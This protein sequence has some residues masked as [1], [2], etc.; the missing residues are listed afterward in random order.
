MLVALAMV[1][2]PLIYLKL[3]FGAAWGVYYHAVYHWDPI[4]NWGGLR[5]PW[6]VLL[7]TTIYLTPLLAGVVVVFFLFKPLFARRR[8]RAQPLA[9]NPANEPVLFAF[10]EAICRVVG[11]PSPR[12]IDL[13]CHLNASAGFRRGLLSL[14]GNDL[15]LTLGL[16]LVANV[17]TK[18]LAGIIA[19]EFGHFTQGAGIR[20]SYIIRSVS[21]WFARVVYERDAWD[22]ALEEW[23]NEI[24]DGR[25]AIVVGLVQLGVWFSRLILRVLMYCGYLVGGYMLRQME[26]NADAYE[27]KV[28]GSEGF[29]RTTR[30]LALL[31][32][33][34]H[35][36]YRQIRVTWN[37]SGSLPDNLPELLRSSHVE[38]PSH[39]RQRIDD[40]LGM[41][42]T[43]A[44]DTHPSP[45]D[46]IREAR[47]AADPGIFEDDRPATSLFG[48]F[49]HPARQVTFLHYTEELG[50]PV[51]PEM[52]V[53][54]ES[55][56]GGG[57][58]EEDTLAAGAV[59]PEGFFLGLLPLI[60]P[61]RLDPVQPSVDYEAD[62]EELRRIE[63][64]LEVV[65]GEVA[66]AAAR[67]AAASERMVQARADRLMMESGVPVEAALLDPD[68]G[69]V[70]GVRKV[71]HEAAET[72]GTLRDSV[73]E[74]AVALRRR[75]QLVLSL[76]IVN[77]RDCDDE[78][79]AGERIEA[80]VARVN[81]IADRQE[82]WK[83]LTAAL[84]VLE[85][86]ESVREA[87]GE[88]PQLSNALTTQV[89]LI[90]AMH[91]TRAEPPT[92][93]APKAGLRLQL[94]RHGQYA[95]SGDIARIRAEL[96]ELSGRRNAA[97]GELLNM[98]RESG[99][100]Q[101]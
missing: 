54:V 99:T 30:K 67:Y 43:G 5:T 81:E 18:E 76:A 11:A 71:E 23:S 9:L 87:T 1:L 63:T 2:L 38:L 35:E 21:F 51:M 15:V 70:E 53:R 14:T 55:E 41:R 101:A 80:A 72:L 25:A 42:R 46:R 65:A 75:L 45:A 94:G 79:A 28:V 40:T 44:F 98:A 86:M 92:Q 47:K 32:A 52:L 12:R 26:Y 95:S 68:E 37:N 85:R 93:R 27:I 7:Q 49:A 50:I 19:H 89:R 29:E 84:G 31:E 66:Q 56:D 20:L 8:R 13:D 6:M 48:S 17:S 10:I 22:V 59:A 36:T 91:E 74:V 100:V 60:E 24:E 82:K 77:R 58:R 78:A 88:S 97:I 64:G 57:T 96:R 3:L 39:A 73:R 34:F 69:G 61:L 4:M 33:A 62:I 16:P 83:E 90:M